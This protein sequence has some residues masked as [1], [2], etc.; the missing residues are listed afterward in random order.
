LLILLCILPMVLAA[1]VTLGG[2]Y[3]ER[4]REL[5]EVAQQQVNLIGA[6]LAGL[7]DGAQSLLLSL[8][9]LPIDAA[10]P[11]RLATLRSALAFYHYFVIIERDGTAA[12]A[13]AS[14]PDLVPSGAA[15]PAWLAALPTATGFSI[16]RYSAPPA[17]NPD[18]GGL[19]LVWRSVTEPG[20]ERIIVAMADL[21]W[22]GRHLG[23][24][25]IGSA[26]PSD[27]ALTVLDRDGLVLARWPDGDRQI[28]MPAEPALRAAPNDPERQV[29]EVV[30]PS[31][32]VRLVAVGAAGRLPDGLAVAA[33]LDPAPLLASLQDAVVNATVLGIIALGVALLIAAVAARRAIQRPT[34]RLLAAARR[35]AAGDMAARVAMRPDRSEFGFLASAFNRMAADIEARVAAYAQQARDLETLVAERTRALSDRNNRLQVEIA[36]RQRAESGLHQAQ[37]LQAVGQ[38]AGGIAHDFN[39]LLATI[40]GSLELIERRLGTA[41]ERAQA[42]VARA[43]DAVRRGSQLTARLLAFSRRQRLAARP[44]DINR[45]LTDLVA[46]AHST[47]GRGVR[48]RTELGE[49]LWRAMVDA[50]QLEAAVVNLA[51]N[52]RD[53]MPRGGTITLTTANQVVTDDDDAEPGDYVRISVAD[54]GE[55]MARETLARAFEP[56]FTTK[57]PGK[58]SGLGLSQVYGLA[59]QSGGAVHLESALGVGTTVTLLLPRA[60]AEVAEPSPPPPPPAASTAA[61]AELVLLVDDDADVRHV[62][63]H[64]LRD[65]GYEVVEAADG[66]QALGVARD[67]PEP[68]ALL[69]LDYAMPAMNGLQLAARLRERG[70]KAPLV[71]ATGYAELTDDRSGVKPDAI[72]H[73]PFSLAQLER[74]LATLRSRAPQAA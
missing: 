74:T 72:L 15:A 27:D 70:V 66:P 2:L 62:A 56:F 19:P 58:G 55:G 54:D 10:C 9:E 73:K 67:L 12:R 4:Q 35:W 48:V 47:L 8:A 1:L 13:C 20:R 60:R 63:A 22:L 59:Q 37:K 50:G 21:R 36:E 28:G 5:R 43:I 23:S 45:L 53:A 31:G 26:T 33:T 39:N 61:A 57:E 6:D 64:M 71:L 44:T 32:A 51:L 16:G 30:E 17:G 52:A 11:A 42:L 69:V 34:Q 25:R 40:L 49:G 41:D 65:L 68:P 29:T 3:G 46:L 7:V 14:R 38:L 18:A 24:L